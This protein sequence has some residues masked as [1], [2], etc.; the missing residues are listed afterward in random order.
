MASTTVVPETQA[1]A[2]KHEPAPVHHGPNHPYHLVDPSPWP[3]IGSF[4]ALLL[5]GGGVMWM[6]GAAIGPWVT[7]LGFAGVI[8]VMIRWW[9]DVLHEV[10][11][12]RPHGRGREG[13]APRHGAVHPRPRSCSSSPSSGPTSGVPWSGPPRSKRPGRRPASSLSRPG[14]SPS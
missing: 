8:Y 12:R 13:P 9:S 5:T 14:A 6:H 7:L 3:L 2:A 1:Q 11:C 4:S 10:A